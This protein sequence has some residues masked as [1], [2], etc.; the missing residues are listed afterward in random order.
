MLYSP[1]A[2]QSAGLLCVSEHALSECCST[3]PSATLRY[4]RRC[5]TARHTTHPPPL[6]TRS[7]F[8]QHVTC[9]WSPVTPCYCH[10]CVCIA[11]PRP[12]FV[13]VHLCRTF[14]NVQ[15]VEL[16]IT[17]LIWKAAKHY[18]VPYLTHSALSAQ[19]SSLTGLKEVELSWKL[20]SAVRSYHC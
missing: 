14:Q 5:G 3:L 20:L 16:N 1:S 6:H 19:C 15:R 4:A 17:P 2:R 9:Q 18:S 7:P 12:A 11:A 10:A 13:T 8:L